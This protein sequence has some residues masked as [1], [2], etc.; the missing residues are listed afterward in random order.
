VKINDL[1]GIAIEAKAITATVIVLGTL[2]CFW[3]TLPSQM[4]IIQQ[5]CFQRHCLNIILGN[6]KTNRI[7]PYLCHT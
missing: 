2:G 1:C 6:K 3:Q 4:G 7:N 5:R